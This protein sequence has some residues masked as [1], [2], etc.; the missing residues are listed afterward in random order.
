MDFIINHIKTYHKIV[1]M[2]WVVYYKSAIYDKA[3]NHIY[4]SATNTKKN[5]A[6]KQ[7][8]PVARRTLSSNIFPSSS[9][10]NTKKNN[11][12]YVYG[13]GNNFRKLSGESN[14]NNNQ[15]G[16]PTYTTYL[17]PGNL[18]SNPKTKNT[19][20]DKQPAKKPQATLET[21]AV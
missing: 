18:A 6:S 20:Q 21:Y 9:S 1:T 4:N 17:K 10:T 13:K 8:P 11:T 3:E 15:V 2:N 12:N 7:S 19:T 5:N 16:N 14:T